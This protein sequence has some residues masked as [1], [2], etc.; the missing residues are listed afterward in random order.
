MEPSESYEV[1]HYIPAA[2]LPYSQPGSCY[3]LVRLPEEDPTAGTRA[4]GPGAPRGG[5]GGGGGP[6]GRG[7]GGPGGPRGGGGGR[8]GGP[9]GTGNSGKCSVVPT[10][11]VKDTSRACLIMNT[12]YFD[13]QRNILNLLFPRNEPR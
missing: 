10:L 5:G 2:S 6:R 12:F 9:G 11:L 4:G 3:S 13:K 1:L 8:A 7:G